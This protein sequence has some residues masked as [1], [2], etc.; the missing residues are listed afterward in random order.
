[1]TDIYK[2]TI[3]L[4][5]PIS[6][7][8]V[9]TSGADFGVIMDASP[10]AK[11]AVLLNE[12]MSDLFD[13]CQARHISN[14][15]P[16]WV[17]EGYTQS[18]PN[19]ALLQTL[20]QG[21]VKVRNLDR[22]PLIKTEIL[23]PTD[24][25]ADNQKSFAPLVLGRFYVHATDYKGR[26]P[27]GKTPLIVNA[28]N[29][30]GT[31]GHGTTAGCLWALSDLAKTHKFSNALDVGTGTGILALAMAKTWRKCAVLATDIDPVAIAVARHNMT[32]NRCRWGQGQG[33]P[34]RT[35]LAVGM[36]GNTIAQ[37]KPYD[38]IVANILARPLRQMAVSLV[39]TLSV[40]GVV[41]LSGL[42][43][44]QVTSVSNAYQPLGL[45]P[46][47]HYVIDNWHTLVLE[48]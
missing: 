23:P 5:P 21:V 22:I 47:A 31:G 36:T 4:L 46:R 35:V 11:T 33:V 40:R 7:Q 30:F 18:P 20:V 3:T 26:I 42:L 15:S 25:V 48:R 44:N 16:H 45:K 2:T 37:N 32:I 41:V 19:D 27:V 12:V 39:N 14:P 13:V 8:A 29:A 1:M 43:S 10:I 17:V 24:W 28:G 9:Y 38:I 6:E 34:L